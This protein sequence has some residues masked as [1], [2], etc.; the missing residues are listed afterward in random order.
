MIVSAASQD[1]TPAVREIEKIL[2]RN[3]GEHEGMSRGTFR[4]LIRDLKSG[5][6]AAAAAQTDVKPGADVTTTKPG[7]GDADLIAAL[8]GLNQSLK[9]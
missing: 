5:T 9:S 3:D 8:A 6:P 1:G 7:A 4:G 2:T